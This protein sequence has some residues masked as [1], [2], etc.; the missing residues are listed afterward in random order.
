VTAPLNRIPPK[1][2]PEVYKTYQ[3]L[4]PRQTHTRRA[5]CAE[6]ECPRQRNGWRTVLDVSTI[7]GQQQAN[8][9]RMKS[10]RSF[11]YTQAG[12]VVTFT[13]AAGQRCFAEHRVSLERE[14]LLRVVGGDWRGNPRRVP[15]RVLRPADWVENFGE[16]QL[17]LKNAFE[18]G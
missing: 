4:Q 11:T 7:Q 15:A 1:A 14:P 9:I 18:R 5:S 3:L 8:W 13:F 6:V 17:T 10:G 16:H 12:T 2:G